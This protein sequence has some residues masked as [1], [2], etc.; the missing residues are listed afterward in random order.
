MIDVKDATSKLVHD[1]GHFL[2]GGECFDGGF[3]SNEGN[4]IG[5]IVQL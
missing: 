4:D 3:A 1:L 2:L 5:D